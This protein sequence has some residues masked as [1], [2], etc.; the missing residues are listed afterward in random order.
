MT[1]HKILK[2]ENPFNDCNGHKQQPLM[3]VMGTNNKLAIWSAIGSITFYILYHKKGKV[4]FN[5][6]NPIQHTLYVPRNW[7]FRK[8]SLHLDPWIRH[9][10]KQEYPCLNVMVIRLFHPLCVT[11]SLSLNY[12]SF[13]G[14][15]TR[16]HGWYSYNSLQT[17]WG[18]SSSKPARHQLCYLWWPAGRNLSYKTLMPNWLIF[19]SCKTL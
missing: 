12:H 16:R 17:G 3:I 9:T 19:Q 8:W 10:L 1:C 11:I 4:L 5:A 7:N 14:R 6:S 2:L 13:D 18:G 15:A